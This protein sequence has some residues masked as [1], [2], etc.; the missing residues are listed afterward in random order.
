[1]PTAWS[2]F[3][4]GITGMA[5]SQLGAAGVS[6]DF[7][8]HAP[9]RFTP[10]I[11]F[12]GV[13]AMSGVHIGHRHLYSSQP[14]RVY[15][16]MFPTGIAAFTPEA[17]ISYWINS[18][19]RF[20]LGASW[21]ITGGRPVDFLQVGASVEFVVQPPAPPAYIPPALPSDE[22]DFPDNYFYS[23]DPAPP[24]NGEIVTDVRAEMI[25]QHM[26]HSD[27]ANTSQDAPSTLEEGETGIWPLQVGSAPTVYSDFVIPRLQMPRILSSESSP[28]FDSDF[29]LSDGAA[30]I[31]PASL[32][33]SIGS[34]AAE[35][36]SSDWL[37][38]T[39]TSPP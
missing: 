32:A 36:N 12:G 6:A 9:T 16:T 20:N 31:V 24:T 4:A 25:H 28:Q 10:Y 5:Y 1:M 23:N 35:T 11:G 3:R 39:S 18:Q 13:A 17:G 2:T 7:R 14:N 21:Y 22:E 30:G 15:R 26:S 8:F 27:R 38:N 19:T 34:E 37:H 33:L 29:G